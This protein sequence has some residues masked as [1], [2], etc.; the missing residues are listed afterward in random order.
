LRGEFG[1]LF[2][3]FCV[4]SLGYGLEVE[5]LSLDLGFKLIGGGT[6]IAD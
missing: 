1:V 4:E 5:L 6:I 3:A 2:P